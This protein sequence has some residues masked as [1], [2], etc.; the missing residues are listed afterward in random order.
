M[1]TQYV[2]I[3]FTI[4][5]LAIIFIAVI[6]QPMPRIKI[7][8]KPTETIIIDKEVE[9]PTQRYLDDY[10]NTSYFDRNYFDGYFDGQYFSR[11]DGYFGGGGD[12]YFVDNTNNKY[13]KK[14]DPSPK[15][16]I[17]PP[18]LPEPDDPLLKP[19]IPPPKKPIPPP[20][21]PIPP[22]TKSPRPTKFP[23]RIKS[24]RPTKSPPRKKPLTVNQRV[25]QNQKFRKISANTAK[26]KIE[27]FVTGCK[28]YKSKMNPHIV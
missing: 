5:I 20:K 16:V 28:L 3:L 7:P 23:P 6:L 10:I 14:K 24:P 22:P 2:Y 13:I 18:I 25:K 17:P 21:T 12:I 1:K 27:S 9:Q 26:G 11:G 4:F 8:N 15:P 19:V